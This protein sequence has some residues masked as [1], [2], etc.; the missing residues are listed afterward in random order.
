VLPAAVARRWKGKPVFVV[1]RDKIQRQSS[2]FMENPKGQRML[3]LSRKRDEQIVIGDDIVITI[4]DIR[5]DKVRLGVEAPG[6]VPVHRHEVYAALCRQS[7]KTDAKDR[8]VM[9]RP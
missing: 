5:G 1:G 6:D 3:V 7:A 8:E 2:A 9:D 4:V